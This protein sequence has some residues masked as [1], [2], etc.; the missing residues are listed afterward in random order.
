[1]TVYRDDFVRAT[2]L[3]SKSNPQAWDAF[4]QAFRSLY[5]SELERNLTAPTDQAAMAQGMGRRMCELKDDFDTIDDLMKK[6]Q[7]KEKK[8]RERGSA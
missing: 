8:E 6:L 7:D 3:L 1:V 5:W 4:V 2:W